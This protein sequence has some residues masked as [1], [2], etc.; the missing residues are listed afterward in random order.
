MIRYINFLRVIALISIVLLHTATGL[1]TIILNNDEF[2]NITKFIRSI[3]VIAVPI[4][5]F[6][7]GTIFLSPK[8]DSSYPILIRKYIKRIF[9]ILLIFALPASIAESAITHSNIDIFT[10]SL[11]NWI[12][13]NSW[14]HFWYLYMLICLYMITPIIKPF[15]IKSSNKELATALICLFIL[16]SLLPTL[17]AIGIP[18]KS[19]MEI[20]TPFIF[21][22]ILGYALH[23]RDFNIDFLKNYKFLL[24]FIIILWICTFS[25]LFFSNQSISYSSPIRIFL[26][27]AIFLL[28]K[29]LNLSS[30]LTDKLSIY[31]FGAYITHAFF[32]NM[33]YK[34]FKITPLNIL[35][36]KHLIISYILFGTIFIILSFT[37]AYILKRPPF[38]KRFI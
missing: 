34:I 18:I 4:Y 19:Y 16:S 17:K 13:G 5:V 31:C 38:I 7:S 14:A 36:G 37:S 2:S 29:N 28:A 26:A 11:T 23:W 27:A 1:D 22:Y 15:V 20:G 9:F 8:K 25:I 32:I 3:T 24:F 6:I 35:D 10:N 33:T 30:K 12:T 21:M